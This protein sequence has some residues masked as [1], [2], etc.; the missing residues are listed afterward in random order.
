VLDSVAFVYP[1]WIAAVLGLAV[2]GVYLEEEVRR[3]FRRFRSLQRLDRAEWARTI[4][5]WS[6]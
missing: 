6:M 3:R 1:L 5:R 4:Q 2:A